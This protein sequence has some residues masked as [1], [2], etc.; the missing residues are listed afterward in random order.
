MNLEGGFGDN[1]HIIIIKRAESAKEIIDLMGS[2]DDGKKKVIFPKSYTSVKSVKLKA[3]KNVTNEITTTVEAKNTDDIP[4]AV[5]E[6]V[7]SLNNMELVKA[8][9]KEEREILTQRSIELSHFLKTAQELVV[10]YNKLIRE[11]KFAA[12][13]FNPLELNENIV[14][15][16]NEKYAVEQALSKL[17]NGRIQIVTPPSIASPKTTRNVLLA[18]MLGILLGLFLAFFI[19]YIGNI[20]NKNCKPADGSLTD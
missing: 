6:L 1:K 17:K 13:G 14:D 8:S 7:D 3:L 9:L 11:G 16:K 19:E 4:V 18:G 12:I 15:I 5:A 20:K 10:A 2:I